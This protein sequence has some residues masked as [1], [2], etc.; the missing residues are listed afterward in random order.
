MPRRLRESFDI[1]CTGFPRA[2]RSSIRITVKV[3]VVDGIHSAENLSNDVG[4]VLAR[5]GR[6]KW[7]SESAFRLTR[8]VMTLRAR[9]PL[10]SV[11]FRRASEF[12][13]HTSGA[14]RRA[15]ADRQPMALAGRI[16]V[17]TRCAKR[18]FSAPPRC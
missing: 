3:P 11:L 15:S 6:L 7:R 18:L 13:T 10:V 5:S 14:I 17:R 12:W 4:E 2:A 8:D 16:V 9:L 1:R